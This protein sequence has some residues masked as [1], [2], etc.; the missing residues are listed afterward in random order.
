[1]WSFLDGTHDA[2]HFDL[3]HFRVSS[4]SGFRRSHSPLFLVQDEFGG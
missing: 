4:D 1:M 2:E 3:R